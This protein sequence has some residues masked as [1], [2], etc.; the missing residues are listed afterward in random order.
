MDF[1][2]FLKVELSNRTQK[3]LNLK[4]IK[5]EE[6]VEQFKADDNMETIVKENRKNE[7]KFGLV[8]NNK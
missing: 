4:C 8:F 1:P 5:E 2:S 6:D 3:M 7:T